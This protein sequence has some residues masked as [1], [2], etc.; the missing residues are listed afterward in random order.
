MPEARAPPQNLTGSFL[1]AKGEAPAFETPTE[2][3]TRA[4]PAALGLEGKGARHPK[5]LGEAPN[6]EMPT[7]ITRSGR[8]R[9][10]LPCTHAQP[11]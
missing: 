10:D 7:S 6:D 1:L 11:N 3:E 4:S 9:F 8:D 5:S 2:Q